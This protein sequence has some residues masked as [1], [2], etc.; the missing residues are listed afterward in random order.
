[1]GFSRQEYCSGLSFPHPAD[2]TMS[3]LFTMT[4]LSQVVLHSMAHSFIELHKLLCYDKDV[5]TKGN[6][7]KN[8]HINE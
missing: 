3:E 4:D 2:H 6:I 5:I 1:M 8:I 7:Y